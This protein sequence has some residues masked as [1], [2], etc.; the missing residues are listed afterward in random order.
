MYI[1]MCLPCAVSRCVAHRTYAKF[2]HKSDHVLY[3]SRFA[4]DLRR[5]NPDSEPTLTDHRTEILKVLWEYLVPT[6]QCSTWYYLKFIHIHS[7]FSVIPSWQF[8]II[9]IYTVL[10]NLLFSYNEKM[11]Y[12]YK[13]NIAWFLPIWWIPISECSVWL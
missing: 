9:H 6:Q 2:I 3:I 8:E 5:A 12:C 1:V 4:F 13:N 10:T 11:Q 7:L